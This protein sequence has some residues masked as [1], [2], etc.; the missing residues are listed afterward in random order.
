MKIEKF[1]IVFQN[2]EVLMKLQAENNSKARRDFQSLISVREIKERGW[3]NMKKEF[4]CNHC[5]KSHEMR[6]S[7][8]DN[9]YYNKVHGKIYCESCIQKIA[10]YFVEN[11]EL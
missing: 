10:H 3:E 9:S 7:D 8:I 5:E 1:E 11:A 6:E 4:K 2:S